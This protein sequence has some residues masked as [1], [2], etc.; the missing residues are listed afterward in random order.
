M[1]NVH[2]FP[3]FDEYTARIYCTDDF[4]IFLLPFVSGQLEAQEL[5]QPKG[6][7]KGTRHH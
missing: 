3:R 5:A 2:L 1:R 4:Q 7:W 6:T